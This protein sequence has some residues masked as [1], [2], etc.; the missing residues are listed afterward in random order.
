MAVTRGKAVASHYTQ[1]KAQLRCGPTLTL[2]LTLTTARRIITFTL[3]LSST[4]HQ[5]SLV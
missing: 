1:H 4:S 3:T 5:G 2:T